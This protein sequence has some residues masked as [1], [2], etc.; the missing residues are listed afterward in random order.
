MN[1]KQKTITEIATLYSKY[2]AVCQRHP[3]G[4][5][6][7]TFL[8]FCRKFTDKDVFTQS[9][10]D[11]W[12][13][14]RETE[15]NNTYYNRIKTAENIIRFASSRG[16]CHVKINVLV[17]WH[18]PSR[19]LVMLSQAEITSFFKACDEHKFYENGTFK[20]RGKCY[21]L[22][23]TTL[24]RLLYSNGIRPIEARYLKVEDVDLNNGIIYIRNTKGYREHIIA[25][26]KEMQER[27][28]YY[29]EVITQLIPGR[30]AFFCNEKGT[31]L[32]RAWIDTV[33]KRLWCKYNTT[34]AVP[35][36]F[37]HN[38]A[39]ANLNALG[40]LSINEAYYSMIALS[41]SMGHASLNQTMYYYS[42]TPQYTSVLS[43]LSLDRQNHIIHEIPNDD[44]R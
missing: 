22:V 6:T 38:Y 43:A 30:T 20:I 34:K 19:R 11:K 21:A 42:L 3:Y 33:F 25:V 29:H 17:K 10:I 7:N 27:L 41:K 35:Y 5:H 37:R 16:Y 24:F 12:C 31:Y 15:K 39:I 40:G 28:R 14:K 36:D 1:D 8:N 44:D 23:C 9:A 13:I 26:N 4:C 32:S 2:R 18:K